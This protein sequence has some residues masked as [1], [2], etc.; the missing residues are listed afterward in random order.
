MKH[1]KFL[2]AFV[3][4]FITIASFAQYDFAELT[5]KLDA[6][7]KELGKDYVALIYKD[8]KAIYDKKFGEFDKKGKAPI[9]AASQWLTAALVMTYVDEGKLSL[10]TKIA[11]YLPIYATYGKKYITIR[12]CLAHMTGI[13]SKKNTSLIIQKSKYDK[14][15]DEV[16]E[17]AKR[18]IQ[19]NA[20]VE[21]WYSN[22]GPN[23]VA[24]VLEVMTKKPF[25]R[26]MMERV[27]RPLEMRG[28]SFTSEKAINAA[29]G[30]T[31]SALDYM[32]F[33]TMLNNKGMFNG[34]K[35]LSEKSVV[36]MQTPQVTQSMVKYIPK[37]MEGYD[38][39]LGGVIQ[40]K[41]DDGKAVEL[42]SPGLFGTWPIIDVCRGYTCIILCKDLTVEAKKEMYTD[43]KTTIDKA[44]GGNCK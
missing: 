2:W 3:C 35:I 23:I 29:G 41:N 13:E 42:S 32:N 24:R 18:E 4:C 43:I 14:L 11:D 30:A 16:N 33:L 20:G 12:H 39:C 27:L 36:E 34:K 25:E 37:A 10:D 15:E 22:I 9:G 28:T 6:N 17:Y 26:L 8:G 7:K 38:F 5:Q 40:Q 44:V 21:F 31:S 19:N 1:C